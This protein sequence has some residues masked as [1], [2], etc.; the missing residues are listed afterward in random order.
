[1]SIESLNKWGATR[2]VCKSVAQE[3]SIEHIFC[4]P[5]SNQRN[6]RGI[7]SEKQ[8]RDELGYSQILSQSQ[9]EKLDEALK[10]EWPLREE[11][12]LEKILAVKVAA[13]LFVLGSS[14][15]DSFHVY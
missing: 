14:H 9:V 12:W 3:L 2:Y 8:I 13:I 1:M 15:I 10:S 4:D 6:S 11:F 5:N 7:R